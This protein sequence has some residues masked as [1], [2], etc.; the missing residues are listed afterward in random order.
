[1]RLDHVDAERLAQDRQAYHDSTQLL[2]QKC[3]VPAA[4]VTMIPS[5]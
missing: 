3:V 1:M 4:I 5:L 2:L